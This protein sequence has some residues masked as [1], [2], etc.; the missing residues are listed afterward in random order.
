M[1]GERSQSVRLSFSGST[2]AVAAQ[3]QPGPQPTSR[4]RSPASTASWFA[5]PENQPVSAIV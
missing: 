4:M 3:N 5:T 2:L 1:P